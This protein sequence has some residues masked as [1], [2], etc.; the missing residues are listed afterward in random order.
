MERFDQTHSWA[1][2][3]GWRSMTEDKLKF[4]VSEA[5]IIELTCP[6]CYTRWET[7]RRFASSYMCPTCGLEGETE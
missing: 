7:Q 5:E 6:R 4:K 1:T 2:R 3:G